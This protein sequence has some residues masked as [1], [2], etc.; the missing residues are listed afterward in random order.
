LVSGCTITNVAA[1]RAT[2]AVAAQFGYALGHLLDQ[3]VA[4]VVAQQV[5]HFL[6]AIQIEAVHRRFGEAP[7]HGSI[8]PSRSNII[9]RL[10]K[11][12]SVS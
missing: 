8:W 10:G 5:V 1:Q 2:A 7:R 11:P 6:E 9:A 12:V 4:G 3:L